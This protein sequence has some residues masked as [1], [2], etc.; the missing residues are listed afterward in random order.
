MQWI[1][2]KFLDSD[3]TQKLWKMLTEK[4]KTS[5]Q[6]KASKFQMFKPWAQE[7]KST[8]KAQTSHIDTD[9]LQ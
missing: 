9:I 7:Q 3:K 4:G 2:S 8:K 5:E 1:S 6:F